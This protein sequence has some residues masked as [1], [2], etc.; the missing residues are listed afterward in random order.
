MISRGCSIRQTARM[1][2]LTSAAVIAADGEVADDVVEDVTLSEE[3]EAETDVT[4]E[5]IE[6]KVVTAEDP[7]ADDDALEAED[8]AAELPVVA[9]TV[10]FY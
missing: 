4:A 5:V 6:P 3:P 7:A 9:A 1:V 2:L 10:P 8:G